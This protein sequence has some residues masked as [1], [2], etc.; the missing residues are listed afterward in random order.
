MIP[1]TV[2]ETCKKTAFN[3]TESRFVS[4]L[5]Y[6]VRYYCGRRRPHLC[7]INFIRY[8]CAYKCSISMIPWT[9]VLKETR[10]TLV[11]KFC[12]ISHVSAIQSS[13]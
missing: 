6:R 9:K 7:L 12:R 10:D 5:L 8:I 3:S 2:A 4:L 1:V 13:Q 11:D